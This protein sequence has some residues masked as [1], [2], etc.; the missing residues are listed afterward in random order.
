M[1]VAEL[2]WE[3]FVYQRRGRGNCDILAA[4]PHLA[5]RL[6]FHYKHRSTYIVLAD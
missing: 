5:L 2:G 1:F 4:F 6:L 3:G